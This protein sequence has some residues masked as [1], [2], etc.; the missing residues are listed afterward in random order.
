ML[1]LRIGTSFLP[2]HTK[3]RSRPLL[4]D[5]PQTCAVLEAGAVDDEMPTGDFTVVVPVSN[6]DKQCGVD[7]ELEG[8]PFI[9]QFLDLTVPTGNPF[10]HY[11]QP[12]S[13][14]GGQLHHDLIV[15]GVLFGEDFRLVHG[16]A[17]SFGQCCGRPADFEEL[18]EV[19][20]RLK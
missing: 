18:A 6:L 9:L 8:V 19:W 3:D 7:T 15:V 14:H 10:P 2:P 20:V 17:K 1:V 12:P 11:R 13:L 5:L 16:F 4:V